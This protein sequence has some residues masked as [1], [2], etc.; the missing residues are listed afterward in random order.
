MGDGITGTGRLLTSA[1]QAMPLV[2]TYSTRTDDDTKQMFGVAEVVLSPLAAGE[3]VLELLLGKAGK[4]DLVT[5][6]FRLIP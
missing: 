1:G 3:Y 5:Y 4:T 6:G 2:V